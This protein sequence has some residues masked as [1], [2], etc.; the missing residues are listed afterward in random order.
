[1]FALA[2]RDLTLLPFPYRRKAIA[3]GKYQPSIELWNIAAA[4][5]R[6]YA[7]KVC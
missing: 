1:M 6:E 3:Q 4:L 7:A 5:Q 2:D